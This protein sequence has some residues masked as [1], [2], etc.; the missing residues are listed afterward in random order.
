MLAKTYTSIISPNTSDCFCFSRQFL[1]STTF[2]SGQPALA[3]GLTV[4]LCSGCQILIML[5]LPAQCVEAVEQVGH[6]NHP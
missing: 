3:K 4:Q 1:S 6:V 5:R 2:P